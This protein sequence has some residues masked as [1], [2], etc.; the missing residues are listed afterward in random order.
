MTIPAVRLN[1]AVLFVSDLE[2]AI[3]FW[4]DAFDM[5]VVTRE[6]RAN[7][8]FRE[9]DRARGREMMRLL[10]ES[11][12][13]GVPAALTEIAKLGRTLQRRAADILA[14]LDRPGTS[15]GPTAAINGR[16]EHR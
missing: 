4:T 13:H 11:I 5:E 8:A 16:L 12:S 10:I 7:A 15:N 2:R 6:P 14:Y 1:H 9:P 3:T